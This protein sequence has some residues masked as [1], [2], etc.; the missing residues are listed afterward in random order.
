MLQLSKR[1][2]DELLSFANLSFIFLSS[3]EIFLLC[4]VAPPS[5]EIFLLCS[6]APQLLFFV[7][8]F[9]EVPISRIRYLQQFWRLLSYYIFE[10]YLPISSLFWNSNVFYI[11]LIILSISFNI[12]FIS[13]LRVSE[14]ENIT[15]YY[16]I[17]LLSLNFS[18]LYFL[19]TILFCSSGNMFRCSL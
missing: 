1:L 12:S 6:V 4:S 3:S 11:R 18:I 14:P 13:F 15:I 5:S 17:C 9:G 2:S 19:F 16:F 8:W 10:C 7:L